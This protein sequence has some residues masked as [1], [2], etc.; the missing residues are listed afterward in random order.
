MNEDPYIDYLDKQMEAI[1]LKDVVKSLEEEI[2][3]IYWKSDGRY[4]RRI[5]HDCDHLFVYE[6]DHVFR[7]VRCKEVRKHVSD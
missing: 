1:S 6:D 2:D 5:V 4:G 7:C 3:R